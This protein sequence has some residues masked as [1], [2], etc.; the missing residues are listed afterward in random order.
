MLFAQNIE[1]N[2]V[3]FCLEHVTATVYEA[4]VYFSK[5]K[6]LTSDLFESADSGDYSIGIECIAYNGLNEKIPVKNAGGSNNP[7]PHAGLTYMT[8]TFMRILPTATFPDAV[9]D[10]RRIPSNATNTILGTDIRIDEPAVNFNGEFGRGRFYQDSAHQITSSGKNPYTREPI[11]EVMHYL[12]VRG[13]KRTRRHRRRS[14]T[15]RSN[16]KRI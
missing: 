7:G 11:K 8:A 14:G 6:Y 2:A 16:P 1:R 10:K 13:G 3:D 9:V 5:Y 12:P 4:E 15:K